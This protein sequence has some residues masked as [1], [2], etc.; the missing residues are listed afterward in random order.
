MNA[1][2]IFTPKGFTKDLETLQDTYGAKGYID[3]RVIPRKNPNTQTGAM[4]LVYEI[5]ENDKSYIEK[6]EIKGNVMTKDRVIRREL[7]VAPGDI[8][9][10][11]KVKRSK[12]R[13]EGTQLFKPGSVQA[14]PEPTDVPARN[15]IVVSC[16]QG[17]PGHHS[18]GC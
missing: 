2:E 18:V 13:L 4:D 12:L 1:G 14:Q 16:T 11:V 7:S 8:F 17:N 3:T 10:M 9:D 5:E 15:N 6:I